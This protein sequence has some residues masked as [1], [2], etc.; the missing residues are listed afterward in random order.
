MVEAII[1]HWTIAHFFF[2]LGIVVIISFFVNRRYPVFTL[3]LFILILW[4]MF[5]FKQRPPYWIRN[6]QN[7]IMDVIV[8]YIAVL[9]GARIYNYIV[10]FIDQNIRRVIV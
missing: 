3:S 6:Y 5:E 4:E 2:G 8:G 10:K 9:I 7:N 1:N